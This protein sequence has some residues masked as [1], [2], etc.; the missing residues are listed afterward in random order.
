MKTQQGYISNAT[1][2]NTPPATPCPGRGPNGADARQARPRDRPPTVSATTDRGQGKTD[3]ARW[4]SRPRK[5]E[6]P[7][8]GY[9]PG[10]HHPSESPPR[11]SPMAM[12]HHYIRTWSHRQEPAPT[13][14]RRE[15]EGVYLDKKIYQQSRRTHPPP[16][17]SRRAP[18]GRMGAARSRRRARYLPHL[19]LKQDE[20]QV[21][22]DCGRGLADYGHHRYIRPRYAG[23]AVPPGG[24]GR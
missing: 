7:G 19:C 8:S 4:L 22:L 10:R 12:R 21:S 6:T 13:A 16:S 15:Q 9:S 14:G 3:A 24:D 17:T 18:G 2:C 23:P 11:Q 1:P 5:K 20:G